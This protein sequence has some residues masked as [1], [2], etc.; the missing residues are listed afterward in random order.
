MMTRTGKQRFAG[1]TSIHTPFSHTIPR[2]LENDDGV[3]G[4]VARHILPSAYL[5]L[6]N[7]GFVVL[8]SALLTQYLP[9]I[10]VI[11]TCY[12]LKAASR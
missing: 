9:T 6:G 11:T 3:L 12:N 1:P 2:R 5:R 7:L 10:D 8:L 4:A